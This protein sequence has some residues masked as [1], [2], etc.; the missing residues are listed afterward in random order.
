MKIAA[1]TTGFDRIFISVGNSG[2]KRIMETLLPYY[3]EKYNTAFFVFSDGADG[4]R[5]G[6]GGALLKLLNRYGVTAD[7]CFRK[8]LVILSGGFSK[9]APVV[10]LRG[11]MLAPLG[12]ATDG[13]PVRILDRILENA[14]SMAEKIPSGLLVCCGDIL[15]DPAALTDDLRE[16][17]AFCVYADLSVGERHGVMFADSAG[18]L[19]DYLQK[20]QVSVLSEYANRYGMNNRV[21]VDAGWVYLTS[22]Y[23]RKLADISG[24][25]LDLIKEGRRECSPAFLPDG[26]LSGILC[27]IRQCESLLS[28]NRFCISEPQGR[29]LQ[30]ADS[31]IR[32]AAVR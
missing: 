26:A 5:I 32:F 19:R 15:V 20:E 8:T 22:G 27:G 10:S 4:T 24:A 16:S 14:S 18:Y 1:N 9:R 3:E 21:P 29:F 31:F 30:T 11:K 2:Q 25:W 28:N 7:F 13:S 6:S 12:I 23:L 17:T